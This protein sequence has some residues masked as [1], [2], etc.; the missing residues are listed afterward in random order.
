MCDTAHREDDALR[1]AEAEV[2]KRQAG[3]SRKYWLLMCKEE[4]R[5]NEETMRTRMMVSETGS[6]TRQDI[7]ETMSFV[8]CSATRQVKFKQSSVTF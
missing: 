7:C 1:T 5:V 3:R 2:P 6:L 8:G 4:H